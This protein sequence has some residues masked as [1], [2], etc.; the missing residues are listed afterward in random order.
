[1]SRKQTSLIAEL[2]D[3]LTTVPWWIGVIVATIIWIVGILVTSG[4]FTR[5]AQSFKVGKP[6]ILVD[7]PAL[8]ALVR[9][10]RTQS[11]RLSPPTVHRRALW[12]M[13]NG[14]QGN[15]TAVGLASP[16]TQ[17]APNRI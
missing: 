14:A 12:E 3:L 17:I 2:F 10:V 4:T 5:D 6:L 11:V 7:G 16:P 8:A 9:E 15:G 1:M 13:R